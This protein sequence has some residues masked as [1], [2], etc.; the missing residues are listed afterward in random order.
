MKFKKYI[1]I[2]T[3][4]LMIAFSYAGSAVA[5]EG[6]CGGTKPP[7]PDTNSISTQSPAT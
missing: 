7:P 1:V 2:L 6:G 3:L 4:V 5:G